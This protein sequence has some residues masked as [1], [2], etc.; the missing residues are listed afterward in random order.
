VICSEEDDPSQATISEAAAAVKMA[1]V[2]FIFSESPFL[3]KGSARRR[4]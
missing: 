2:S 1:S 3:K 4:R